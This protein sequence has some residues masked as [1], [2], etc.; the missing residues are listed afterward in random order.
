MLIEKVFKELSLEINLISGEQEASLIYSGVK[1]IL[2]IDQPSLIMDIGGGSTEF[3][4]TD[5]KNIVFKKSF[6]LGSAVLKNS[7][8][9][10]DPISK[11]NVSALKNHLDHSLQ[12][13]YDLIDDNLLLIGTS[14]SFET[15][16]D[17]LYGNKYCYV[18]IINFQKRFSIIFM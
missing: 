13:L 1:H 4:L 12:E 7:F 11:E 10:E 17:I 6:P 14:G 2:K 15:I 16:Y 3:I 5:G 8:H 18:Y 9:L